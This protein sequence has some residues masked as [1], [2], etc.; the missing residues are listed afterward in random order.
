MPDTTSGIKGLWNEDRDA[1]RVAAVMAVALACGA[2][3]VA[4]A[5]STWAN[6]F[7]GLLW[8]AACSSVGWFLGFLFGI[9][10]SLST[11][12]A[13]TTAPALPDGAKTAFDFASSKAGASRVSADKAAKDKTDAEDIAANLASV[14]KSAAD[15]ASDAAR[16]AA[17]NPAD[18]ALASSAADTKA[19]ADK[20]E[21][22]R[23][24]ADA[25][26]S[27][28]AATAS[29]VK[30]AADQA[31]ADRAA[32]LEAKN[33]AAEVA[34]KLAL[35]QGPSTTVNTNLEQIS[36]WLTKIIVGVTLVESKEVLDHLSN[37]AHM[38]A[39]SLGGEKSVSFAFAI[40][41][42]FSFSGLLGSY[43]L[44][45]LFLQRA[46]TTAAASSNGKIDQ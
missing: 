19:A 15:Q 5:T 31:E 33:A 37:A 25:A 42:Y 20:A 11:D 16:G 35:S 4:L 8:A 2:F 29:V 22:A 41:I 17:Q 3:L 12:T 21:G 18:V 23:N 44:T 34:P 14:A 9:P 13:R 7:A 43:L 36:D 26:A 45:R 27:A 32:A 1:K 39:G 10:R 28:A 38:M 30:A 46:F 40:L 6:A 24:A